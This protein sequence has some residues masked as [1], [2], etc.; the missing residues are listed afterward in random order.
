[1]PPFC[2]TLANSV[3]PDQ[4]PHNHGGVGSGYEL[5]Q[6]IKMRNSIYHKVGKQVIFGMQFHETLHGPFSYEYFMIY[7]F[8]VQMIIVC[9]S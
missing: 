2:G 4:M 7:L 5:V 6:K 9:P 1:M 3:D 8:Y